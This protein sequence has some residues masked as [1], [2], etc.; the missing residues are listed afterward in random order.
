MKIEA[1]PCVLLVRC[2]PAPEFFVAALCEAAMATQKRARTMAEDDLDA[3]EGGGLDE[4]EA[5]ALRDR[6]ARRRQE[7]MKAVEDTTAA[8]QAE[9]PR[10]HSRAQREAMTQAEGQEQEEITQLM[11]EAEKEQRHAYM[12]KV[13]ESI[14][15]ARTK[16]PGSRVK[17]RLS[18]ARVW[19]L[20]PLRPLLAALGGS[21]LPGGE[22]RPTGA[23]PLPWALEPAAS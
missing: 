21:A 12:Q 2:L 14:Q 15:E 7:A 23:Q 8:A 17:R 11:D 18:S 5:Q 4:E 20:R 13:R 10:F 3:D 22:T 19:H 1:A 16:R 6:E 9:K